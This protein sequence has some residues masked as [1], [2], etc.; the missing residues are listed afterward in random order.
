MYIESEN[1]C[2]SACVKKDYYLLRDFLSN[3]PFGFDYERQWTVRPI[4]ELW[5]VQFFVTVWEY[6]SSLNTQRK[7]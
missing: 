4:V 1:V 6:P 7:R 3:T 5:D 2:V